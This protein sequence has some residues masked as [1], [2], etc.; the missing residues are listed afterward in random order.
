MKKIVLYL[1]WQA[2]LRI[3]AALRRLPGGDSLSSLISSQLPQIAVMLESMAT[4]YEAENAQLFA[5]VLIEMTDNAHAQAMEVRKAI[6]NGKPFSSTPPESP[7]LD[8]RASKPKRAKK[9]KKVV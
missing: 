1:D 5:D 3:R 6:K 4:A 2:V 7:V 8:V 9:D